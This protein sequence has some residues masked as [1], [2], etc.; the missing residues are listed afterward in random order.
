MKKLFFLIALIHFQISAQTPDDYYLPQDLKYKAEIPTPKQFLGFQV[1][2]QHVMPSEV[3]AYMKELDRLSDRITLI[4]YAKT[5]ENRPLL[6]LTITSPKNHQNI[7]QIKAEHQKLMNAAEAQKLDTKKMPVVLW[8]G[9][10]VHGN[11]PSGVNASLL[12]AYYLAAAEG[13]AID[14]LLDEAVILLDPC[15]N[16][17]GGNRFANWVNSNKSIVPNPDPNT[18]ELN[19]AFPMGRTNHYWFD[20]NRDWLHQQMPESRGRLVQFYDWKPNIL[21]DHHE[22]GSNSSFFFQP[23]VPKRTHPMTPQRNIDLT[24]KIGKYHAQFLDKIGSA[25]YTQENF[26]DFYYGKGSTLPDVNGSVGIL[27]EQGS[28]RGHL[29]ETT[30]GLLSFAFTIRNQFTATLSTLQAAKEMRVEMLDYM[31]NFYKDASPEANKTYV[32][33]GSNDKAKTAEMVN[34]LR[35][36]QIDVFQLNSTIEAEKQVFSTENSFAVPMAQ[37]QYRLIKALFER[38]T[39]FEDSLFYDVSAFTLPLSMDVPFSERMDVRLGKKVTENVSIKGSVFGKSSLSYAFEWD[40]YFAPRAAADLMK[41]GYSLKVASEP[42]TAIVDGKERKFD[43]GTVVVSVQ[44]QEQTLIDLKSMAERDGLDFYGVNTGLTPEGMDFG[45]DGFKKMKNPKVLVITGPGT[46]NSDA[47]EIWHLLDTRMSIPTTMAEIEVV[48]RADLSKYTH[49]AMVSGAYSNLSETKIKQFLQGGGVVIGMADATKWL[50]D[51]GLAN[52]KFK[53]TD[54]SNEKRP[55][56]SASKDLGALETGG[57]IFEIKID[58]T[59]PVFYGY[60]KDVL[61][62]F[63]DNNL[64]MEDNPSAYMTPALFSSTPLMAGYVHPKNEKIIK[65]SASIMTQTLGSG[66]MILMTEN[67]NFRAYWYGTN[68]IFLN[69]LFFGS[70]VGVNRF[71]EED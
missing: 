49:I 50:S 51:K 23:G 57:A 42:F 44:N 2:N 5:F 68:K 6:L 60:K 54:V 27:F 26:D 7:N 17:D 18:R 47:G 53:S 38:R 32:F 58:R 31:R 33:G 13:V 34:I 40:G 61:A 67:P 29:R 39:K 70:M 30:N 4:E 15:I 10:S 52:I 55:F 16:P 20:L 62:V 35:R 36:N 37:P 59:H 63:K 22:M 11:E 12:A 56:A 71:S 25:Y 41:K 24:N 1:G 14:S 19:E 43:Y 66:K 9:Y 8:M 69:S 46:N 3:V 48:N 28:S 64:A 21:T 65:N 45:S